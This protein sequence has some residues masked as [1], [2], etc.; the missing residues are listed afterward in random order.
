MSG[1]TP[2]GSVS[3]TPGSS[4]TLSGGSCSVNMTST[5][6]GSLAVS[7]SYEGDA[8]HLASTSP[9][10]FVTINDRETS[11]TVTCAP[12]TL[13]VGDD[14]ICSATVTDTSP[15][16][17]TTPTGNVTFNSTG[18]CV[19]TGAGVSA[20]CSTNIASTAVG[21]LSVYAS[22]LG[23]STHNASSAITTVNIVPPPSPPLTADFAFNPPT[24]TVGQTVNFTATSTGGLSPYS[25]SW[26]FGDGTNGSGYSTSHAYD[27]ANTY[28]VVLVA[29]DANGTTVS[30]TKVLAVVVTPNPPIILT[31]ASS[32]S[33]NDGSNL[34]FNVSAVED[35]SQEISL[36]CES[37]STIGAIFTSNSGPGRAFGT[38]SWTPSEAQAPGVYQVVFSSTDGT[39]VAN[40]TVTI[41]VN[42]DYAPPTLYVPG[43][44]IVRDGEVLQ[45]AVNA[46]DPDAPPENV[47]LTATGLPD[48][49]SFDPATGIFY[50]PIQGVQ[51]GVY[52][53]TFTATDSGI[54]PLEDSKTVVVHV[55]NGN[56]RCFVCEMFLESPLAPNQSPLILILRAIVASMGFF[57][58]IV[59]KHLRDQRRKT[60]NHTVQDSGDAEK[61]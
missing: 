53:L 25:Y 46:T 15:G 11:T 33:V 4:C 14:A 35:S 59:M 40:A 23:D 10:V 45:F 34:T 31:V 42:E 43:T 49:S 18:S 52:T 22:Y 39:Q 29:T 38:F 21:S 37:C 41:T 36:S 16:A 47:T 58:V 19:L 54:P 17:T 32:E 50:W 60:A 9:L 56:G 27:S 1:S 44:L 26:S 6:P 20:T 61:R 12:S 57:S 51:P 48:G 7:A 13:T 55:N 24:P 3:F 2:T 28:S 8:E 30:D 5:A